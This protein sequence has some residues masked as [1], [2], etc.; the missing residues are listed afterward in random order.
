MAEDDEKGE[1]GQEKQESGARSGKKM[2]ILAAA[3]IVTLQAALTFGAFFYFRAE[4]VPVSDGELPSKL[5]LNDPEEED[6]VQVDPLL[7]E[8]QEGEAPLGALFP[9]DLF[10]VN[11]K[12]KGYIRVEL[13]LM[14]G[15]RTVPRRVYSRVPRLRDRI[16]EI[17]A[18]KKRQAVLSQK[19]RKILREDIKR[20]ADAV[21]GKK[22]VEGV[23]FT[24][25]V[26]Q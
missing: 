14:F 22:L 13:Q 16:I 26:V 17:L 8:L 23:L 4:E 3:G 18:Q 11:L 2:I 19:G 1:E 7:E 15:E 12:D 5:A 24:Q 9:M 20:N 6:T 21:I 10:I 25:Y